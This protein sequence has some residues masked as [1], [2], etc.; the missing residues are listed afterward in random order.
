MCNSLLNVLN[1]RLFGVEGSWQITT[2][3]PQN[4]QNHENHETCRFG[5]GAHDMWLARTPPFCFPEHH[6]FFNPGGIFVRPDG[7]ILHATR[8][9]QGRPH[10]FDQKLGRSTPEYLLR[11][12]SRDLLKYYKSIVIVHLI[13]SMQLLRDYGGY[14]MVVCF[15]VLVISRWLD[16]QISKSRMMLLT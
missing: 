15:D 2:M 13:L 7:C 12:G 16:P 11:V 3:G 4:H 9:P 10:G 1:G 5:W 14:S 8:C 6:P